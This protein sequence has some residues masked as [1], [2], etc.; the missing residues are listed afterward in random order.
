MR[1]WGR[2]PGLLAALQPEVRP[3][4]EQQEEKH[5]KTA[6]GRTAFV[7]LGLAIASSASAAPVIWVGG[8]GHA[9]ELVSTPS[10][11]DQALA[12]ASAM[13]FNGANG[14]LATLTSLDELNFIFNNVTSDPYWAAGSDADEE[15]VWQWVAGPEAGTVFWDNGTTLTYANWYPLEPNNN[16]GQE[17]FL[18]ANW[19]NGTGWNDVPGTSIN[20]SGYVVEY[21]EFSTSAVPEPATWALM[22]IGFGFVGGVMRMRKRSQEDTASYA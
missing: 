6:L 15:G 2:A 16:L 10:T 5:M 12:G 3:K 14:Y 20:L 9:Y 22:L 11:W 18:L 7:G 4:G 17:H 13:T 8:N 1:E 21:S 19:S